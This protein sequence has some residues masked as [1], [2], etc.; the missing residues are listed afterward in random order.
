MQTVYYQCFILVFVFIVCL[1]LSHGC[2]PVCEEIVPSALC[3]FWCRTTPSHLDLA[4]QIQLTRRNFPELK[5]MSS[6]ALLSTATASVRL[7]RRCWL[8]HVRHFCMSRGTRCVSG[9]VNGGTSL[10][11][12]LAT[13]FAPVEGCPATIMRPCIVWSVSATG[14]D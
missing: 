11:S 14:V 7:G 8:S 4:K 2:T 9:S 10:S 13:R 6:L 5:T 12:A 1:L 3:A